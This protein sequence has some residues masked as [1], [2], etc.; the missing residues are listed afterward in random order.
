MQ[1]HDTDSPY[2]C[3]KILTIIV[4]IHLSITQLCGLF[5]IPVIID[6]NQQYFSGVVFRRLCITSV[7]AYGGIGCLIISESCHESGFAD[8]AQRQEDNVRKT[9]SDG[10]FMDAT[11]DLGL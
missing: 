8:K 2:S 4:I 6:N 11:T 5:L 1:K 7:F 3:F 10:Q 9:P